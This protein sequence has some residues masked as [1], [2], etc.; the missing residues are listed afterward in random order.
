MF[1]SVFSPLLDTLQDTPSSWDRSL[2]FGTPGRGL[3]RIFNLDTAMAGSRAERLA[4]RTASAPPP[5]LPVARAAERAGA[6]LR[7]TASTPSPT[8]STRRTT[9][10]ATPRTTSAKRKPP[11]Y[12][13]HGTALSPR[14]A[15]LRPA[16]QLRFSWR[17]SCCSTV[18]RRWH[19]RPRSTASPSSSAPLVSQL[20]LPLLRCLAPWSSLDAWET[21]RTAPRLRLLSNPRLLRL[22][23]NLLR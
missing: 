9:T 7:S 4:R 19:K 23:R 11:P 12:T 8:S 16:Q 6:L 13:R 1:D 21:W 2:T 22:R 3:R 17:R 15:S 5:L 10:M 20:T 14:W 18:P